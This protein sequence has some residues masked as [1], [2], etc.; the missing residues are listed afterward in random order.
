MSFFS[1]L[2][3]SSSPAKAPSRIRVHIAFDGAIRVLET[4]ASE[5]WQID[6]D[7]RRGADFTVRVLKYILPMDPMPLALLAKIYS[8][9]GGAAPPR[10]PATLDWQSV[11]GALF[12]SFSNVELR[13]SQ[14]LT[15]T[16]S[17]T[18]T[19]AVLDGVSADLA[20][21]LRIRE[22]RAVLNHEEFIVTAMG[23]TAAFEQHATEIEQWFST[24]AF[25]P[26]GGRHRG[27]P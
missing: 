22:R 6:E 1:R 5:G 19:E 3:G 14:Q 7:Q 2:F 16:D 13:G 26:H 8:V 25:V 4:P 9:E 10:D 23:S 20:V 24:S 18:A 12:S 11:F 27:N 17:L 15:M 21:P